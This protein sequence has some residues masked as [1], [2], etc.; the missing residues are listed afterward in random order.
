MTSTLSASHNTTIQDSSFTLAKLQFRNGF[1]DASDAGRYFCVVVEEH[2]PDLRQSV[3]IVLSIANK[4]PRD[5]VT[6]SQCGVATA[7]MYFQIRVLGILTQEGNLEGQ[8]IRE[9]FEAVIGGIV[10]QCQDCLVNASSSVNV[11]SPTSSKI[12]AGAAVFR[13]VINST[14][15]G[16]T[17]AIFCALN[18][19]KQSGPLAHI[20][21]SLLLIDLDC[22]INLD[23]NR[24]E[25]EKAATESLFSIVAGSS[26]ILILFLVL[27]IST[28]AVAMLSVHKW[29]V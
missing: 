25:C 5:S 17:T 8:V 7:T 6:P 18:T 1:N 15:E 10:S 23:P 27:S 24:T 26:G 13:G 16:R 28:I 11:Y 29:Y 22:A 4:H 2:D 21:G 19:W 12:I 20:N 9:F 14:E 3:A